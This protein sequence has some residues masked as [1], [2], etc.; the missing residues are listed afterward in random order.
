[1]GIHE[2]DTIVLANYRLGAKFC[3]NTL[4]NGGVRIFTHES[5]QST[6]INLNEFCKEKDLEICAVKLH[7]PSYEMC[8]KTIYRSPCGNFQ[9]FSNNLRKILSMIYSNTIE[10]VICGDIN[11]NYLIDST[12]N[13]WIHYWLLTVYTA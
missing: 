1:M 6:N 9:Y 4:E 8:I 3:I 13:Y 10:I 5:I 2:I 12:Y 7:L 11:I